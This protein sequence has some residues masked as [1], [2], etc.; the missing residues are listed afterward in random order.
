[1]RRFLTAG[2]VLARMKRGD[3]PVKGGYCNTAHFSDGARASQ[4]TMTRLLKKGLVNYPVGTSV[5]AT[6]TLRKG[7]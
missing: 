6:W 3:L 5:N 2:E 4:P 7:E 1:M